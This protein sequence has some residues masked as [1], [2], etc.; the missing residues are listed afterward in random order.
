MK[1]INTN[2]E[3]MK[4]EKD[5]SLLI[6]RYMNGEMEKE[7][8]N[9][10]EGEV[11]KDKTLSAEIKLQYEIGSS[12]LDEEE[13]DLRAQ[14][15]KIEQQ[16]LPK[17]AKFVSFRN[18]NRGAA[19][20]VASI[21]LLLAVAAWLLL[22][23]GIPRSNDQLFA[24]YYEPYKS[25]ASVRSGDQVVDNLLTNALQNYEKGDF[26]AALSLFEQVLVADSKD[27]T[28]RFYQ[29]ISFLETQKY[30]NAGN[31]FHS[32]INHRD[33]L[34]IEQ[35]QWYLGLCYLRTDESEKARDQFN[36]IV[37]SK[38]HYSKN[39]KKILRAMR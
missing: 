2:I 18:M 16:V 13:M 17:K 36:R 25:L 11:N 35:A 15:G 9:W 1:L 34:F 21:L 14:L 38:G 8:L 24:R 28:S 37:D 7:E 19:A 5:F 10:F 31:S 6:D 32:V 22:S 26:I 27:A 30:Q 23:H 12:I 39:A 3:A 4:Q 20:A 33:N 29:G